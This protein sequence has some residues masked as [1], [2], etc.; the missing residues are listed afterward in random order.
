M[1]EVDLIYKAGITTDNVPLLGQWEF[2]PIL[3]TD[4]IPE[5]LMGFNY[6]LSDKGNGFNNTIHFYLDDYQFERL[7]NQPDKYIP[8]LARYRS[9]LTPD[10]SLFRDTPLAIQIYSVFKS[11]LLGYLMEQQGIKVIPTLQWADYKSHEWVFDGLPQHKVYSVSTVGVERDKPAY[12][13]WKIGMKEALR[14]VKPSHLIVYGN[15]I[16]FDFK[17]VPVTFIKPTGRFQQKKEDNIKN[18]IE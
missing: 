9:C 10:F 4:D 13:L 18:E 17:D 11:R 8:I 3:G 16:G 5:S 2:P 14:H 1:S 12:L 6:C 7:W 15:D